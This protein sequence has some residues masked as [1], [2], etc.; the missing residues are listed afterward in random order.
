MPPRSDREEKW[1]RDG[2][3]EGG[4]GYGERGGG[5]SDGILLDCS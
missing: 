2:G 1:Q 5:A 3:T 4:K